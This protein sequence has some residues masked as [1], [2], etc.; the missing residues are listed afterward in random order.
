M[1]IES[2]CIRICTLDATGE[3]CLG[4][5]RTLDE[6]VAWPQLS[7]GERAG[8]LARLPARRSAH[9]A[10]PRGPAAGTP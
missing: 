4:C 8:V 3:L 2:P 10:N 1:T 9:E 7:E 6:I 5:F